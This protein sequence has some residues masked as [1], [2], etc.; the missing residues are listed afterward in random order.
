MLGASD[1][2]HQSPQSRGLGSEIEAWARPCSLGGLLASP[3][4][5]SLLRPLVL[6]AIL[7]MAWPVGTP[8][9][10]RLPA[11]DMVSALRVCPEFPPPTRTP[12]TGSEP[13]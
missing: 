12:V 5:F 11:P 6:L 1:S 9:S 4:A 10:P 8:R 2:S 7:G 13:P 3:P